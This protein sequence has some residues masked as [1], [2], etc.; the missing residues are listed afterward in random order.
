M[1]Y[2]VIAALFA[3]VSAEQCDHKQTSWGIYKDAKC[4]KLNK[5]LQKKYGQIKDEDVKNWSGDCEAYKIPKD[6]AQWAGKKIGLQI[7][8]DGN[9]L[10]E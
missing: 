3:A 2:A 1:K 5:K 8:C 6:A 9:G 10:T 4:T 7:T